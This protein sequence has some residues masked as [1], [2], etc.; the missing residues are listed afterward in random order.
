MDVRADDWALFCKRVS[1]YADWSRNRRDVFLV[2]LLVW[3]GLAAAGSV[4]A[5]VIPRKW[6]V[7]FAVLLLPFV[8]VEPAPTDLLMAVV[9][10]RAFLDGRAPMA[11]VHSKTILFLLLWVWLNVVQSAIWAA[12]SE[13][14]RFGFITIY[15][16]IV[17]GVIP[18]IAH[19]EISYSWIRKLFLAS[20]MI[21]SVILVV[22]F[23]AQLLGLSA[24]L[25]DTLFFGTRAKGFFKDP[26]VAGPFS[27]VGFLYY[28]SR[29]TTKM[30]SRRDYASLL[31]HATA[32][33]A[34]FSRGA[35]LNAVV[36]LVVVGVWALRSRPRW[37]MITASAAAITLLVAAPNVVGLI[38]ERTGQERFTQINEYDL[39]R[40][41]A[42][43]AGIYAATRSPLGVGPA[44]YEAATF[45]LQGGARTAAHETYLRV[46][47]ENGWIGLALLIGLV[48][49]GLRKS[50]HVLRKGCGRLK[51][52]G[53]WLLG[54]LSGII[55][56][57]LVVDTLHWRHLWIV[58]GLVLA[59][60][61]I[62]TSRRAPV[63]EGMCRKAVSSSGGV[64]YLDA[65]VS[66]E[67][68]RDTR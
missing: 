27:V 16:A 4:L 18:V 64:G 8:M 23:A 24:V 3:G 50:I 22:S 67:A 7:A 34:S 33:L 38:L 15:L 14:V 32:V 59:A 39:G 63:V 53:L 60:D 56:E 46:L 44:G 2:N 40:V 26:N 42:W 13:A 1:D 52:D 55:A 37:F 58:L 47:V 35:V 49:S 28:A 41:L 9:I 36:G 10:A 66:G 61:L 29:I 20:I 31:L 11:L 48:A 5:F 65:R 17:A 19:T 57:G 51:Q 25:P 54:S 6:L 12:R 30:A 43:Q 68:V 62:T 21:N 45:D